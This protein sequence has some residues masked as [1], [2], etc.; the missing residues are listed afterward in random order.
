MILHQRR[1]RY[2]SCRLL[3]FDCGVILRASLYFIFFLFSYQQT[4]KYV[5]E[6]SQETPGASDAVRYCHVVG[7]QSGRG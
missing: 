2:R 6:R 4:T 1:E 5:F 7:A 3:R